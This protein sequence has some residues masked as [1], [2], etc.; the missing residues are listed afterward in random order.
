MTRLNFKD[1]DVLELGRSC[2]ALKSKYDDLLS[3]VLGY[4]AGFDQ[5]GKET[6]LK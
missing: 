1:A 6:L 5:K 4:A 3:K 2:D